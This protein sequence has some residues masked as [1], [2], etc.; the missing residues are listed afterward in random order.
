MR[1]SDRK[2]IELDLKDRMQELETGYGLMTFPQ[3][4]EAIIKV[5]ALIT[6]LVLAGRR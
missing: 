4:F 3:A 1:A 5:L 2:L 6:K